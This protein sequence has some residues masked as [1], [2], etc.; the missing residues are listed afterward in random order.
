MAWAVP[1]FEIGQRV[2]IDGDR[3]ITAVVVGATWRSIGMYIDISWVNDGS[4]HFESVNDWRLTPA[5]T[6][7]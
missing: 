5:E 7:A 4:M 2:H 3:S 6:V 1:K